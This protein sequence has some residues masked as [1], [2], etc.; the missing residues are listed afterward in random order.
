MNS[1]GIFPKKLTA[2]SLTFLLGIFVVLYIMNNRINDFVETF[3]KEEIPTLQ[4]YSAVSRL[5][6]ENQIIEQSKLPDQD[7]LKMNQLGITFGLE[8]LERI[9]GSNPEHIKIFKATGITHYRGSKIIT[10]P[11][12]QT[13]KIDLQD[14]IES[15]LKIK[16]LQYEENK[17]LQ[18]FIFLF[19]FV[20]L[21]LFFGFM[22]WIYRLFLRNMENLKIVSEKL[23]AQRI[24]SVNSSKMASLGEM[25]AGLAHEINNPLSVIMARADMAIDMMNSGQA[26]DEILMKTLSKVAEMSQRISKIVS[27]MRKASRSGN[28][29]L[30]KVNIREVF[31]DVL[32]LC[33]QNLKHASIEME[34]NIPQEF[35]V[36][37]DSGQITQII[38]NLI[39]NS[40]DELK[41]KNGSRKILVNTKSQDNFHLLQISDNAGT[42]PPEVREKLFTPFYTSKEVGKGTGLGL[43][44]SLNLARDMKGD[45]YLDPSELTTFV[46][47]LP[48]SK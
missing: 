39:N 46:L 24:T 26:T 48:V 37:G 21:I 19:G 34:I 45:L 33:S 22:A 17:K 29:E 13:L 28:S 36:M 3:Y 47:K 14:S 35:F 12:L 32:N 30:S 20:G 2:F 7:R 9:L 23:E 6:G 27:S 15:Y 10:P 25:A 4:I 41:M 43:S 1:H 16:K 5:I 44:L 40:V 11:I 31:D 42:I 8:E 18:R 38:I